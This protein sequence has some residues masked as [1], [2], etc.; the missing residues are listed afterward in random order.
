[1]GLKCIVQVVSNPVDPSIRK[2]PYCR[3]QSDHK[4][5]LQQGDTEPYMADLQPVNPDPYLQHAL[6]NLNPVG[7]GP[8]QPVSTHVGA[9]IHGLS[10][11]GL[12]TP[13][14]LHISSK[15]VCRFGIFQITLWYI[16]YQ[17]EFTSTTP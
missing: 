13:W 8:Q 11:G 3:R 7:S 9:A 5:Q 4:W 14:D 12:L 10:P 17:A 16:S 15:S 1:M 6:S 2:H